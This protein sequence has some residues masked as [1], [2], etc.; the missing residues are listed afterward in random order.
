MTSAIPGPSTPL[1]QDF[2]FQS[3]QH[4]L[5]ALLAKVKRLPMERIPLA[6]APGRVLG[7]AIVADRDSPALD[8][9]AMDGYAVRVADLMHIADGSAQG[10]IPVRGEIRIGLEPP[11]LMPGTALRIVTGAAI[12][13]GADAVVKRELV[14]EHDRSITLSP[15]NAAM[16]RAGEAVRRR[17][18]NVKA[19][20]AM[21][22]AGREISA[23][24][25]AALATF[26]CVRPLVYR[27][28]KVGILVTGDELSDLHEQITPWQIRDSNG[29]ALEAML[30]SHGWIDPLI[31]AT[32]QRQPGSHRSR[33]RPN[34]PCTAMRSS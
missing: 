18:E 5:E 19:G 21:I 25:A 30:F 17:G 3:P 32:H 7:E 31:G 1:V 20:Q 29:P 16:I 2:A 10:P 9:S 27:Q 11:A 4:A 22:A 24:V 28:V 13:P 14:R 8:V 15:E 34:S 12:P 33:P 23:P 26:G 6:E